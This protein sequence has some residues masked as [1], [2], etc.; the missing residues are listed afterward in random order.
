MTVTVKVTTGC[1]VLGMATALTGYHR[2]GWSRWCDLSPWH[3]GHCRVLAAGRS[4]LFPQGLVPTAVLL[5]ARSITTVPAFPFSL[6]STAFLCSAVARS[7][8]FS[9]VQVEMGVDIHLNKLRNFQEHPVS[10]S[11]FAILSRLQVS[12][13]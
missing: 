8:E 9:P 2:R 1:A 12:R 10:P 5:F 4:T 13:G 11:E 6:L 7:P 3:P